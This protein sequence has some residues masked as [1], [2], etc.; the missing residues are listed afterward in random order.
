MFQWFRI[1][2]FSERLLGL[3]VDGASVN[4]GIHRDL[5]AKIKEEADW[6]QLVCCFIHCLEFALKGAFSNSVFKAVEEFLNEIHSLYQ[7]SPKRYCKLQRIAEAYGE[8][9]PKPMKAYRMRWIDHKLQAIRIGLEHY[10]PLISH[11]ESLS[12]T[13]SLPKRRAQLFGF[14]KCWKN[15]L[16]PL[17]MSIYLYVLPPMPQLYLSFQKDLHDPVKAVCRVQEFTWTLAKLQIL[18]ENTFDS[19][20]SIMTSYKKFLS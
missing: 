10:R 19:Q 9:I 15:V 2:K 5:R 12:Q 11:I 20:D 14:I 8:I 6:L 4:P 17:S 1:T 18:N 13:D 7:T 16:L 3:N